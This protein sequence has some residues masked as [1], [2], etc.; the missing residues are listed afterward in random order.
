MGEPSK[1]VDKE[2][3]DQQ[4]FLSSNVNKDQEYQSLILEYQ[5]FL[6]KLPIFHVTDPE[7]IIMAYS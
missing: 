1:S 3:L 5:Q 6:K 2:S 4:H 7:Y